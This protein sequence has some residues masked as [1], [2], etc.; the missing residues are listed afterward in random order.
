M[1]RI[2]IRV[3]LSCAAL[4][5]RSKTLRGRDDE[6]PR[7]GK[8]SWID[9]R[10]Q[11]FGLLRKQQHLSTDAVYSR[12][13]FLYSTMIND[14]VDGHQNVTSSLSSLIDALKADDNNGGSRIGLKPY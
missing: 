13:Q 12:Q 10:L 5:R 2:E 9:K 11:P 14:R 6:S 3:A 7:G 1:K 4:F 8:R